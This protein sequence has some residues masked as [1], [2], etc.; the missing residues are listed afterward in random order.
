ML[1]IKNITS[2]INIEIG[3]IEN[4]KKVIAYL[5][6]FNNT[7]QDQDDFIQAINAIFIIQNMKDTIIFMIQS[8]IT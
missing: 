5:I 3:K 4:N 8:V 6:N 2:R 1:F 7:N